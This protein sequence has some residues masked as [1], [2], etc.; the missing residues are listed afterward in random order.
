MLSS[1]DGDLPITPIDL[2]IWSLNQASVRR[3][4]QGTDIL[5]SDEAH[6]LAIIIE[7]K[8][9]T[10][11]HSDQLQSYWKIVDAHYPGWRVIGLYLTPDGEEPS[12]AR[13]FSVDYGLIC[14]LLESL[15]QS[16]ASTLGPDVLTVIT[17]YTQMLR[18]HIMAES[19]IAELCRSI[20]Q[21]HKAALDLIYKHIPGQRAIIRN[22]LQGIITGTPELTLI[23]TS[24]RNDVDFVPQEWDVPVA[25]AE[26]VS[27][28]LREVLVFVFVNEPNRLRLV[29]TVGP[30]PQE[31]RQRLLDMAR[32]KQPPFNKRLDMRP[33]NQWKD[34][35][36]RSFPYQDAGDE[37]LTE[38]IKKH[39]KH[40]FEHDLPQIMAAVQAE[41]WIWETP[42][43]LT[44]EA[45][46]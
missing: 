39:W 33:S 27:K 35:F 37:A 18:R 9:D 14:Q 32:S 11:E 22:V 21:K 30:E 13:Y 7:N 25:L 4:W 40:F 43:L 16:R 19:E 23:D 44:G 38:E 26:P 36:E 1:N 24:K 6:R 45:S 28:R 3:E 15:V 5:V 10:G 46:E 42:N 12:D 2:D 20:Y 17:H 29:L 31:T 8:I 34:I 41:Q